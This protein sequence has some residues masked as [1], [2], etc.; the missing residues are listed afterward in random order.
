MIK[1]ARVPIGFDVVVT[2]NGEG[3]FLECAVWPA[4]IEI[5]GQLWISSDA[6]GLTFLDAAKRNEPPHT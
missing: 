2:A 3:C 6:D 4:P 1:V 5:K